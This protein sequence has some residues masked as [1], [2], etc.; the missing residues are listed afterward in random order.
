[1]TFVRGPCSYH[2]CN[3]IIK[4]DTVV[5]SIQKKKQLCD[6][7]VSHDVHAFQGGFVIVSIMYVGQESFPRK[8]CACNVTTVDDGFI[9]TKIVINEIQICGAC[10]YK[11]SIDGVIVGAPMVGQCCIVPK[12]DRKERK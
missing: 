3:C 9:L 7:L 11:I 5:A 6:K 8:N 10:G 2:G 1:M 12:S 4:M